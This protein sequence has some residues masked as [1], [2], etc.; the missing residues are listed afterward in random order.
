MYMCATVIQDRYILPSGLSICQ[1]LND[2]RIEH[3]NPFTVHPVKALHFAILVYPLF[4]IF[5]IR[6]SG[7]LALN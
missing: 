1:Q 6:R 7:A 2:S 3:F 5:D 4:L